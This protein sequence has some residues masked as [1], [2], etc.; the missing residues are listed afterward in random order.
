[1]QRAA[2][3]QSS[4]P[5]YRAFKAPTRLLVSLLDFAPHC[6]QSKG[7]Q[8]LHTRALHSLDGG[9]AAASMQSPGPQLLSVAPM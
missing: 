9:A 1:M 2:G 8:L 7:R 5:A 6:N 3:L 4:L